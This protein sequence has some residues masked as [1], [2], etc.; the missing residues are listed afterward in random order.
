MAKPERAVERHTRRRHTA[1]VLVSVV[2]RRILKYQQRSIGWV[3][4][5]AL[6]SELSARLGVSWGQVT[7]GHADIE[8]LPAELLKLFSQ[9]SVQVEAKLAKEVAAWVDDRDGAEPDHRTLWRLERDAVTD[10]RPDK[11]RPI[12]AN[13]LHED[14]RPGPGQLASTPS[15]LRTT[16]AVY[17]AR[18]IVTTR[19]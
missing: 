16:S 17:R 9:R 13:Q 7:E 3:Y 10:S 19:Q 6:R 5:A 2:D 8:G 4:A 12:A 18:V 11:F 14:G 15:A 1:I